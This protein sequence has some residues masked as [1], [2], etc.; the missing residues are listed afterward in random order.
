MP[1]YD[2]TTSTRQKPLRW[3]QFVI[4]DWNRALLGLSLVER[5]LLVTLAALQADHGGPLLLD[6]ARLARVC[7]ASRGRLAKTM[8]ALADAGLLIRNDDGLSV[9]M[10]QSAIEHA[11]TLSANAATAANE[12]HGKTQG[13]QREM[14]APAGLMKSGGAARERK[15][16]DQEE[17]EEKTLRK[18]RKKPPPTERHRSS[19]S[20]H[21]GGDLAAL[22]EDPADQV[23]IAVVAYNRAAERQGWPVMQNLTATRR[24]DL[25]ARLVETGG[26]AG[27]DD[28]LLIAERSAFICGR[29]PRKMHGFSLDWLSKPTNLCKLIEGAYSDEHGH[30]P[31]GR[32]FVADPANGGGLFGAL[33]RQARDVD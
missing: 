29:G 10:M 11:Q 1:R 31:A 22:A 33:R 12:R 18:E 25:G 4:A 30:S 27:W 21:A 24:A 15:E 26:L 9:A 7:G 17:D 23:A 6:D 20:E 32:A 5:G 13:N 3:V 19:T 8:S 14:P 2:R 28:A 16:S